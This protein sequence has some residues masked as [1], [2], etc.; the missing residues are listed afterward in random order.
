MKEF[1]FFSVN[2]PF[3]GSACEAEQMKWPEVSMLK[4][5]VMPTNTL[6]AFLWT[7]NSDLSAR[8]TVWLWRRFI[9]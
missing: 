8:Q 3:S 9:T 1:S 6:R 5:T 2:S 4:S 7:G